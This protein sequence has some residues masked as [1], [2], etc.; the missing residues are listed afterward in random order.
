VSNGGATV[1]V[2]SR[3]QHGI[4]MLERKCHPFTSKNGR[5]SLRNYQECEHQDFCCQANSAS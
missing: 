4:P 5:N 2:F 3:A 1:E